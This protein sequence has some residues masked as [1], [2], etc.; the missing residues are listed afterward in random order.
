MASVEFSDATINNQC[1]VLVIQLN[2]VLIR[3]AN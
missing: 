2:V 3:L 1:L